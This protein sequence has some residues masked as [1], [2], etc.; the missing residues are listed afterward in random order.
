MA[1]LY[2]QRKSPYWF[3][4]YALPDGSRRRV[5]TKK[6]SKDHAAQVLASLIAAEKLGRQERLTEQRARELIAEIVERTTGTRLDFY[7][8]RGWF[9]DWIKAKSLSKSEA[10]GI[11]Y[12]QP[13]ENFIQ[14]LGPR[15]DKNLETLRTADIAAFW[16][17]ERATGKSAYTC[18]FAVKVIKSALRSATRLAGLKQNPAEG[19]EIPAETDSVEREILTPEEIRKLVAAGEGDWPGVI[20][21]AA[22]TGMRLGDCVNLKWRGIDLARRVIEFIPRK[23]ARRLKAG[24]KPKKI[25]ALLHP[26][27]E[28]AL[29]ALPGADR[30]PDSFVFPSLAGKTSA[31]RS[32][33]SMAFSRIMERAGVDPGVR[34]EASGKGRTGRARTFHSLRHTFLT[35]LGDAG[36]SLEHR[37]LLAGHSEETMTERYSHLNVEMLR[38]VVNRL[39][40]LDPSKR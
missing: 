27:L 40:S 19:F 10:T 28:A 16:R 13:V 32:G 23:T 11:R 35:A 15:A 20:R 4:D 21:L 17:S 34:R 5:S 2:K 38:N 14:S 8:V 12:R 3:A 36:V 30:S 25:F 37:K 39:P 1:R 6:E 33:L 7:T 29:S 9:D 22:F 18:A 31:G 24:G 26:E